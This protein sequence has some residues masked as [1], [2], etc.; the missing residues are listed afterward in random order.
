MF[1]FSQGRSVVGLGTQQ[2]DTVGSLPVAVPV[3]MYDSRSELPHWA[4]RVVRL[5]ASHGT[6]I[7]LK[8]PG[9]RDATHPNLEIIDPRDVPGASDR[10]TQF[11]KAYVHMSTAPIQFERACFER[12]LVLAAYMEGATLN[13][14]WH[15]DTDAVAH[16]SARTIGLNLAKAGF[17]AV[18]A[19]S[20]ECWD[21]GGSISAGN[22]F[23]S[24][25]AVEAFSDF[26]CGRM[27]GEYGTSLRRWFLGL[28]DRGGSGGVCDMTAWGICL[29]EDRTLKTLDTNWTLVDDHMVINSLYRLPM[30][31]HQITGSSAG[32]LRVDG[33][34]T[35]VWDT[36]SG[37]SIPIA[38]IHLSGADKW[39][40]HILDTPVSVR[41]DGA[42]H[43]AM[44]MAYRMSRRY[45]GTGA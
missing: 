12:F 34:G 41:T 22:A 15:M 42:A 39:L 45:S 35:R 38:A 9:H 28:K 14:V 40:G 1:A 3:V 32:T 30:Q 17:D 43:K 11:R 5:T 13:H 29:R 6:T 26:V 37:L 36:S 25:R 27:F 33:R 31:W 8:P 23:L 2:I 4:W 20:L 44:R 24:Q 18:S 19:G 7:L 21:T 10:L 16:A